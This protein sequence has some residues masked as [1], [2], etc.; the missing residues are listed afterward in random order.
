MKRILLGLFLL[1]L[2]S[3]ATVPA[4]AQSSAPQIENAQSA[5]FTYPAEWEQHEAIWLSWPTYENIKGR[6]SYRVHMDIIKA[7]AG[8]VSAHVLAQDDKEITEI[9]KILLRNKIPTKHVKFFKIP[10]NDVWI[11]DMGPIFVKTADLKSS[12]SIL[13]H[14]AMSRPILKIQRQKKL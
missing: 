7:L 8:H 6:P 2:G 1:S 4:W 9:K 10:H 3:T 14:G 12:T 11:R 13:T 5:E